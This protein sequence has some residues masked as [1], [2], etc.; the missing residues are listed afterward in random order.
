VV[1]AGEAS[2]RIHNTTQQSEPASFQSTL[3]CTFCFPPAP[4]GPFTSQ[5]LTVELQ[6]SYTSAVRSDGTLRSCTLLS[7][8]PNGFWLNFVLCMMTRCCWR[9]RIFCVV[10]RAFAGVSTDRRVLILRV[11]RP[12]KISAK[13][14]NVGKCS[15]NHTGSHAE[16]LLCWSVV[17]SFTTKLGTYRANT[18]SSHLWAHKGP[19][20]GLQTSQ[21]LKN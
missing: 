10:G 11:K 4:A 20:T 1:T 13:M 9:R 19:H 2:W 17:V 21:N 5:Q 12:K 6:R 15:P 18:G 14:V 3:D 7:K 16:R 8:A